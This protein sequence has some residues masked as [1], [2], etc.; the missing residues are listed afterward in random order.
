MIVAAG[1]SLCALGLG[2]PCGLVAGLYRFPARRLMLAALAVPLLMPAFLWAIGLSM[3]RIELGLSRNGF[4]SG[5]SGSIWS[6]AALATPLV[7]FAVLV[8]VR[9]LPGTAIDAARLAGGERAVLRYAGYAA[10]PAGVTACL[11]GGILS[12][13]D[14][15]PGQI[16]GFSGVAT[17]I[18]ISF[19]ALYDFELAAQQGLVT[20]A[21]VLLAASPLIWLVARHL[22]L[23]LLPREVRLMEPRSSRTADWAGPALF[24]VTLLMALLAPVAGLAQPVLSELWLDSVVTTVA[25]TGGN[26]LFY[27]AVAGLVATA[28]A[29]PLAICATRVASLRASLLAGLL[30]ILV[31]PPAVGALGTV[32]MAS[33]AP[34]WLDP[35]FRSRFTVAAVLGLRLTAIP[36]VVLMRAI[37]SAPASWALAGALHGVPLLT[38][39]RRVLAPFLA[40]PI[41]MSIALV[42]LVATADITTVLLL[43]PPGQDSLSIALFTV[44]ANAPESMVASLCLAYLLLGCLVIGAL[45]FLMSL[46]GRLPRVGR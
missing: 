22:T 39:L 27:S 25:R 12:L 21:I 4:L 24:G 16:L 33:E 29:V 46:K 34:V 5:A 35:I 6:F 15:G 23:A 31:L 9:L 14:P 2:F 28:S 30:L 43:Q 18:L 1:A 20:A 10:L 7:V 37:G 36:T 11:L 38:Y 32:L 45:M 40:G 13:S 8:A 44:M 19:S 3:L 17:Q 42:A 26:T 41:F